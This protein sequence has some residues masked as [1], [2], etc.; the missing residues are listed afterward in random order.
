MNTSQIETFKKIW[1]ESIVGNDYFPNETELKSFLY[2]TYISRNNEIIDAL[3]LKVP[4]SLGLEFLQDLA[5]NFSNQ[6]DS[7]IGFFP[8]GILDSRSLTCAGNTM[9]ATQILNSNGYEVYYARPTGHSV[10]LVKYMDSYYWVDTTNNI[11]EKVLI[12]IEDKN[13]F[14]VATL[15]GHSEKIEY[16][17]APLLN[18]DEIIVNVFGN[19][20]AL[21]QSKDPRAQTFFLRNKKLLDINFNDIKE[22]L[23]KEYFDYIRNDTKFSKEQERVRLRAI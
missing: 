19:I 10:C 18:V 17:I 14:K 20:E 9:L 1:V 11:F 22:L 3:G 8:T 23:F 15:T 12:T 7:P 4:T 21:K 5:K 6:K 13:S 2:K 16:E